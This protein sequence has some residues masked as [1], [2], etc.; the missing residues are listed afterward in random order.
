MSVNKGHGSYTYH[1]YLCLSV[2]LS[3]VLPEGGRDSAEPPSVGLCLK[4][5]MELGGPEYLVLDHSFCSLAQLPANINSRWLL[6]E[7]SPRIYLR[8]SDGCAAVVSI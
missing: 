3:W 7:L 4:G 5:L 1:L 8:D 2:S 6:S